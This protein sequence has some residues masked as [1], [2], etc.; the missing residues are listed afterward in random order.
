V[1]IVALV[2]ALVVAG[3]AWFVVLRPS[4]TASSS[5]ASTSGAHAAT[6]GG[7]RAAATT[8]GHPIYWAGPRPGM[9][10]ELTVT[11]QDNAYIRY[12]TTGVKPGDARPNFVTVGTYPQANAY[13]V[14]NAARNV[15]NARIQSFGSGELAVSYPKRPHS[16]YVA[17]RGSKYMVEVFSPVRLGAETLVRSGLIVPVK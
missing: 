13:Q 2:V 17:H 10:Y 15:K 3:A 9:T 6:I 4:N 1:A 12:L 7:L 5:A 14:L 11:K 16:V 8:L